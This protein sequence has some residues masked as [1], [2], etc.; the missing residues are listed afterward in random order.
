MIRLL[1]YETITVTK[2]SS[3]AHVFKAKENVPAKK[4]DTKLKI[5]QRLTT[6]NLEDKIHIWSHFN[7]LLPD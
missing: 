7:I 3:I 6:Y 5:K 4:N 2:R 1:E